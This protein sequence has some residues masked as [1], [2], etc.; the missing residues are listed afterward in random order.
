ME[1]SWR[2]YYSPRN[3]PYD[4]IGTV[5][6]SPG[7]TIFQSLS[8]HQL[9]HPTFSFRNYGELIGLE[10]VDTNTGK[11]LANTCQGAGPVGPG[12]IPSDPNYPNQTS[13]VPDDRTRAA[14]FLSDSGLK[15]DGTSAG[16]GNSLRNFSYL[17]LSEDHTSG[18]SGTN[19]PRSQ[20]AQNDQALGQI[21]SGLSKSSYWPS[22]AVFVV[23]DDSQDG[24]DHVDGHRNVLLVASPWTKQ[25]SGDGCVPGYIGHAHYDQASVLRTM[26][27]IL[28][29]APMSTYD[30]SAPPMYDLFQPTSQVARLTKGSLAPYENQR[31]PAFVDETVAS[32]PSSNAK[33]WLV[34]ASK[35]LDLTG[36]DRSGP[37]LEAVL[38]WS[39]T[40]RPL[41]AEL[42]ARLGESGE[43]ATVPVAASKGAPVLSTVTGRPV[44]AA[45]RCTA[46]GVHPVVA[47][48][49]PSAGGSLPSTGGSVRLALAALLALAGGLVLVRSRA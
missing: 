21:V 23:E 31:A 49:R 37:G 1:K 15:A 29:V 26:E 16:N 39:L 45:T 47:V 8:A 19:T 28:G 3:R 2:Q 41:P 38:W 4:P 11:P 20:V 35:G 40:D 32:L 27:L 33:D 5:V 7:C 46:V 34:N 18:L 13:L 9:T 24:F 17:I 10:S 14:E 42:A 48:P 12:S 22:T 43:V 36:I 25:V 30:A 44:T 6:N